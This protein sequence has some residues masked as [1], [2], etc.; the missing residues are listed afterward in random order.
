MRLTASWI[1]FGLCNLILCFG[2]LCKKR[3]GKIVC[4][5]GHRWN[6]TTN[7]CDECPLGYR[8]IEC[9]FKCPFPT[10]GPRCFKTC[11][12]SEAQ[13]DFTFGCKL[14]SSS[15]NYKTSEKNSVTT[16]LIPKRIHDSGI[17]YVRETQGYIPLIFFGLG[18]PG[19]FFLVIL[20]QCIV[21]CRIKK[22]ATKETNNPYLHVA[23]S[24]SLG[25]P[26]QNYA[27]VLQVNTAYETIEERVYENDKVN[28]GMGNRE[29]FNG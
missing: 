11:N 27:Q 28:A 7:E 14:S 9:I 1:V 15:D 12:C 24:E 26:Q 2:N 25:H 22:K 19:V 21:I 10:Y 16:R 23:Q 5:S 3:D 17:I 18:L 13:C 8:G 4:C 20:C 29:D 6:T